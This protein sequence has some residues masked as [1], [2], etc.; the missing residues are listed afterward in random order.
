MKVEILYDFE[1]IP[2][3]ILVLDGIDKNAVLIF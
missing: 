1:N 2:I 3:F